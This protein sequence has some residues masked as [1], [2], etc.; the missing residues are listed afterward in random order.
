VGGIG[1]KVTLTFAGDA[2]DLN[3]TIAEV[4]G[5]LSGI[6]KSSKVAGLGLLGMGGAGLAGGAVAAGGILA[7]VA[8]IGAVGVAVATQIP[9]VK[10]AFTDLGTHVKS[11]LT[12]LVKSSGLDQSLIKIAGELRKS[13][14]TISPS[15]EP[16][17]S[18]IGD[19]LVTLTEGVTAFIQN[20]MPG[21]MSA[22]A[23]AGPVIDALAD[24]LAMMGT[25]L[26]QFFDTMASAAPAAAQV[27]G[28]L[29]DLIGGLLPVIG[30]LVAVLATA[31]GPI[32]TALVPIITNVATV[33]GQTLGQALALMA[34][35][36]TQLVN[37][38]APLVASLLPPLASLFLTIMSAVAPLVAALI[39]LVQ[40]IGEGLAQAVAIVAPVL[41]Q[42]A[43]AIGEAL[44]QAITALTPII[45]PL[46][47]AILAILA[48]VVPLIP[49][50]LQIAT[51]ALPALA[52]I[53]SGVVVP[54]IQLLASIISGVLVPVFSVVASAL[55]MVADVFSAVWS[56]IPGIVSGAIGVIKGVLAWFGGLPGMFRGWWDGAVNAVKTAAGA[57]VSFVSG[58]PGRIL[59]AIGNLGGLLVGAGRSL[60]QG[61]WN[62]IKG[63]FD[64]VLGQ[65]RG[66]MTSLRN[67][68]PFSP[69]KEGPFSGRGYTLYSGR[70]LTE[71]FA[72][73]INAGKPAVESALESTMGLGDVVKLGSVSR[74]TWDALKAQ[75]WRGRAGDSMEALYRPA[76]SSAGGV[77]V[78]FVGNTS[79]ALA[80]VIMQMIRTGK[81]QISRA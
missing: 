15:L 17:F 60:I 30:N 80:T 66:L 11:T 5:R 64:W 59:G 76:G 65:A 24:G 53:I 25:S 73:G 33:I 26:S 79:D 7:A 62:G 47:D 35:V 42:I 20:A 52:A 9:A 2:K 18:K 22:I 37:A 81:I 51:A 67:L 63:M 46:V 8:A 13:F 43:T 57:M 36:V 29:F 50:I 71:D 41:G 72:K 27:F 75:G 74:E 23:A 40:I 6:G 54:I 77:S 4:D 19:L 48:A 32:F 34:P 10:S 14:D 69:A 55:Q 70:A 38:L 44:T 58:L 68:F 61:L 28:S 16:M 39:P 49:P 78:R 12:D 56:A 31:L 21:F 45:P 1:P 3:K